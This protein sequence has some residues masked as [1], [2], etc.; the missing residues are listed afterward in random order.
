[1]GIETLA[2]ATAGYS[3]AELAA[4]GREAGLQAIRRGL[5]RGLAAHHLA[6]SNQ[7]LQHALAALRAKRFSTCPEIPKKHGIFD[8]PC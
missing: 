8:G 4:L 1:L 6:I 3:G 5:A 7:D 2:E